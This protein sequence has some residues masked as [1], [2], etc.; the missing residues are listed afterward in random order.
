MRTDWHS[1]PGSSRRSCLKQRNKQTE[2]HRTQ[3][4]F[5]WDY[6]SSFLGIDPGSK[7]L[8]LGTNTEWTTRHIC[9]Q[10]DT[11]TWHFSLWHHI[12]PPLTLPLQHTRVNDKKIEISKHVIMK[13]FLQSATGKQNSKTI[14]NTV[15]TN[16]NIRIVSQIKA[17]LK[18]KV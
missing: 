7:I 12:L 18:V 17:H 13:P 5:Y 6:I 8:C 3:N 4:K 9:M 2:R 1:L 16:E 14:Q 15:S 11:P 10:T